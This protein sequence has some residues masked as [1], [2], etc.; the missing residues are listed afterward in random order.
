MPDKTN[1]VFKNL[2]LVKMIY[3]AIT[4]VFAV[5]ILI[6]FAKN[7]IFL[8]AHI[9]KVFS[10]ND[11]SLKS[12]ITRFDAANYEL[13]RKRFGWPALVAPSLPE[14]PAPT[15]APSAADT[16]SS[17]EAIAST[18]PAASADTPQIAAEK[19]AIIIKIFSGPEKSEAGDALRD[20]LVK[21]GFA[22]AKLDSHQLILKNTIIQ[23]KTS[24]GQLAKYAEAIKKIISEKYAAQTGSDLPDSADYDVSIL[25][26]KK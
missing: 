10:G 18:S 4:L 17:T 19:A 6:M 5:I 25:I 24:N 8:S 1:N 23:F 16:P 21:A 9:N 3:P 11:A 15:T 22:N 13:I 14:M 20:S 2:P 12:G 26:G 7:L